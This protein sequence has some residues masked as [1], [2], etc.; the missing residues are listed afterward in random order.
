MKRRLIISMVAV[1][2]I[3]S[4][5]GAGTLAYFRSVAT[6]SSNTFVAGTLLLGGVD[7]YGNDMIEKFAS[8]KGIGNIKPGEPRDVGTTQLKNVGTLPLKLYRIT[9]FNFQG[10]LDFKDEQGRSLDDVMNLIIKIGDEQVY[11][12]K[13]SELVEE[14]GG[15]FD[16]IV[17]MLPQEKRDMTLSILMDATAGNEF[18]GKTFS[19]DLKVWATQNEVPENGE[20]LGTVVDL[21]SSNV[22]D[23][24]IVDSWF[25]VKGYN[26]ATYANFDYDWHP[27]DLIFERYVLKIKHEKGSPDNIIDAH[28]LVIIFPIS[29][30]IEVEGD[31]P[32][33]ESHV[34]VDWS[35]DIVKIAKAP[36][37]AAGWDGFEVAFEGSR[38]LTA[39]LQRIFVNGSYYQYWSLLDT[40]GY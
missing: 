24:V 30:Q 4:L 34:T 14:N 16:P 38:S 27:D 13:F 5:A 37:L 8:L 6:S 1:A 39:P 11:E 40:T 17:N 12:G 3:C 18:Q 31:G 20:P 23:G 15:F 35:E 25:S 28:Q 2:L 29:R 26:D 7:E 32:L 33:N 36:L 9:A 19:C 22:G 21:G 10:D